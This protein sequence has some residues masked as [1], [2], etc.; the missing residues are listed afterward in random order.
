M[1]AQYSKILRDIAAATT[2][3]FS[4]FCRKRVYRP[5]RP[6]TPKPQPVAGPLI[7]LEPDFPPDPEV[8][9]LSTDEFIAMAGR[10]LGGGGL[11][12]GAFV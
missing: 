3:V 10:L 7:A 5:R 1:C 11:L 12:G 9:A 6:S 8:E 4:S 2:R